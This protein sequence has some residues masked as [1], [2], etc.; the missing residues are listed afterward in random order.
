MAISLKNGYVTFG[1][2]TSINYATQLVAAW[3]RIDR[4][5]SYPSVVIRGSYNVSSVA[6]DNYH[7]YPNW[8][9]SMGGTNYTVLSTNHD[10]S[11]NY[12]ANMVM[13]NS[14]FTA[15][16]CDINTNNSGGVMVAAYR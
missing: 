7:W 14:T 11:G 15:T 12:F 4:I 5:G 16:S 10:D 13:N 8:A 3:A 2:G 6:Y 1:D 9:V